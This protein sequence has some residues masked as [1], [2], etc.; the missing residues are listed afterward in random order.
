MTVESTITKEIYQGNGA[1]TSFPVPFRYAQQA[2]LHLLL[3][4]PDG[5]ET[6][7]TDNFQVVANESGDTSITYPVAGD[8]LAPG[9]KLVI[10]RATPNTQIVD[11][12]YG[13]A[14]NPDMLEHDA[15]DRLEMQIQE[16]QELLD[17]SIKVPIASDETPEAFLESL[18]T[19]RDEAAASASASETS[20]QNAAE[21]EEWA[22]KWA[23]NPED[24]V[25]KDGEY[26]AYHWAKKSEQQA[27]LAV[28]TVNSSLTAIQSAKE[29]AV[30]NIVT[31]GQEQS[32]AVIATGAQVK[33]EIEAKLSV[34]QDYAGQAAESAQLAQDLSNIGPA[35]KNAFGFVRIGDGI[36]VE[37]DGTISVEKQYIVSTP[38]VSFPSVV[39]IGYG[40]EASMSAESAVPGVN[41]AEFQVTMGNQDTIIV[42]ATDN[43]ATVTLTPNGA[44][45]TVDRL[46]IIAV[47]ENDNESPS[48]IVTYIQNTVVLSAPAILLPTS[49]A[50]DV[51]L[52]PLVEIQQATITGITGTVIG[53]QIQLSLTA[54]FEDILAEY[55]GEDAYTTTWTPPQLPAD[56]IIHVRARHNWLFYGWSEWGGTSQFT[57]LNPKV[58]AP[59]IYAPL[60]E[61]TDVLLKPQI[62]LGAFT[63]T[64][65]ADT[66]T[67][68][69]IQIAAD[70]G[71]T[72]ITAEY[73][74]I[75]TQS[76][77]PSANLGILTEYYL[78]ARYEGGTLGW[79][80]WSATVFFIT[81]D[82]YLSAPVITSPANGA[83]DVYLVPVIT[84]A[85]PDYAAQNIQSKQ[86]QISTSS[87]FA[88]TTW[89][90]GE[91]GYSASTTIG[92]TLAK[93][94]T[95]YARVR[96][97]GSVTGWS[98]WS[99]S[100]SFTT[101]NV[102]VNDATTYN[103]SGTFTVPATGK[104][105]LEAAGG[106]G[107]GASIYFKNLFNGSI[108]ELATAKGGNGGYAK[109]VNIQLTKN[110]TITITVGGGGA[111]LY[112]S[113]SAGDNY[114]S[115]KYSTAGGSSSIAG[116]ITGNGGGRAGVVA[117]SD[118]Q[119]N[120]S[121]LTQSY[122]GSNGG[123][124]GGNNANTT[125]GGSVG[126]N[127]N[128]NG[129]KGWCRITYT[130]Q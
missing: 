58:L 61:S 51:S 8:P 1:A 54:D 118:G 12:V 86:V 112:A 74:S 45:G 28:E 39:G 125:G 38:T 22:H 130:G 2:D 111:K 59:V 43:A 21:S 27:E 56:T 87:T 19:A 35:G 108:Y 55:D 32:N 15:L 72:D 90:S 16:K 92:T 53:T 102:A 57:T 70:P 52:D 81:A 73:N 75:Y 46:V 119:E 98:D 10:Y 24:D 82:S 93:G 124:S 67:A 64:G 113:Y 95:Y 42:E 115:I 13:G 110:Q 91:V 126:G 3:V 29:N 44:N 106:G 99:A 85:A 50:T 71:F 9:Y 103:N 101:Q 117:Y 4:A 114:N 77:Q 79:S 47:D 49:E 26:S 104:Y 34:A 20:A 37:P 11:L 25:V 66:P 122:N 96:L 80:D 7:I 41:I 65:P 78:R 68:T 6:P 36:S 88:S 107:G 69:H 33:T 116:Y 17:R 83:T 40:Y 120:E 14:F 84:T 31:T 127:G 129:T 62:T 60:D 128:A 30:L 63:N 23:D 48:A 76:W 94:T 18:Y 121:I 100:V 105:T 5:T 89:D 97:K 109:S 123:A